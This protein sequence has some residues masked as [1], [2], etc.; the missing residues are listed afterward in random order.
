MN[1]GYGNCQRQ[2]KVC[3]RAGSIFDGFPNQVNQSKYDCNRPFLFYTRSYFSRLTRTRRTS[4]RASQI[5][6]HPIDSSSFN[7]ED[8]RS[9]QDEDDQDFDAAIFSFEAFTLLNQA[10]HTLDDILAKQTSE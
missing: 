10:I 4:S 8:E 5:T 7:E 6:S 3:F 2:W 1:P 9:Q